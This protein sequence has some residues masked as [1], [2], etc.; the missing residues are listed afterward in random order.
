MSDK[1]SLDLYNQLLA[2]AK[3]K[4]S[5]E[6][7]SSYEVLIDT[8]M[9]GVKDLRGKLYPIKD[10]ENKEVKDTYA[11]IDKNKSIIILGLN[12]L[13]DFYYQ[14]YT[15]GSR[16]QLK[17]GILLRTPAPTWDSRTISLIN[18]REIT[19]ADKQFATSRY[20]NSRL[21]I[22]EFWEANYPGLKNR[23]AKKK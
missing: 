8:L 17:A 14:K 16:A 2:K 19:F 10:K 11:L 1:V 9:I 4:E 22:Y 18:E 23:N 7:I 15:V 12:D 13:G 3:D 21:T 6:S 5:G 20:L